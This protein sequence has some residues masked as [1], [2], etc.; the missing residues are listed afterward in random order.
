[1]AKNVLQASFALISHPQENKFRKYD[2]LIV[3]LAITNSITAALIAPDW[4]LIFKDLSFED[5][6]TNHDGVIDANELAAVV[7]SEV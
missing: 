6:D 5:L 2:E 1:M 7:A 3:I 4:G